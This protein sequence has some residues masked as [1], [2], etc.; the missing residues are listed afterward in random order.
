MPTRILQPLL[1]LLAK[2]THSALAQQIEYLKAEN[3]ILRA[4]LPKKLR[5]TP[6]ERQRLIRAGKPLGAKLKALISVVCYTTF[7]SWQ[8]QD[9]KTYGRRGIQGRPKTPEAVRALV[10]QMARENNWGHG[11]IQGELKTLRIYLS[12]NT[13]KS[14]LKQHGLDPCPKHTR[15]NWVDF[16]RRHAQTLWACDFVSKKILTQ[17]GLVDCFLLFFINVATRRVHLA[18]VTVNPSEEW[19][20][21][22]ARNLCMF[23]EEQEHQPIIV[24]HDRDKKFTPRFTHILESNDHRVIKLPARSPNLN[25]YAERWVRS[26]RSECLNHFMVFGE[27]HMRHL[28]ET[29]VDFYNE[30]RPHQGIGNVPIGWKRAHGQGGQVHDVGGAPYRTWLGGLL[31]TYYRE[32]G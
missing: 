13:I 29:Y 22:Q 31:K 28:A 16:V 15:G 10:V 9:S 20:A 25:A 27:G 26:L 2:S 6:S 12:R 3:E 30:V 32:T 1:F 14:I 8:R 21:Q 23:F 4:K 19:M 24:I 5:T 17:S 11:R 18:G 7:L